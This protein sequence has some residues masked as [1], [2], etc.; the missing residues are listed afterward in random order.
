[1]AFQ[2]SQH[3]VGT[4]ESGGA[5]DEDGFHFLAIILFLISELLRSSFALPLLFPYR[6][7]MSTVWVL[8]LM[9]VVNHCLGVIVELRHVWHLKDLL[10]GVALLDGWHNTVN[11]LK[12]ILGNG[13][14]L[15]SKMIQHG[16]YL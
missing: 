8:F 16:T 14:M 11:E 3:E 1:M 15:S 12:R 5:G 9:S 2:K 6:P 13:A 10:R 4:D 7:S